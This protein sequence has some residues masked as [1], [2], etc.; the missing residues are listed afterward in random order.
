MVK[1]SGKG[2]EYINKYLV[3]SGEY[4]NNKRNGKG[5]EYNSKGIIIFQGDYLNGKKWIGFGYDPKGIRVYELKE[6][7]EI[8]KIFLD[9]AILYYEGEYS[10][11]EKNGQGKQYNYKGYL[12]FEGQ[13]LNGKRWNGQIYLYDYYDKIESIEEYVD[14]KRKKY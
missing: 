7:K 2:K 4:K 9:N 5:Q 8:I 6:V 10:N 11:G 1:K 3:Y 12:L 14:G 13:F